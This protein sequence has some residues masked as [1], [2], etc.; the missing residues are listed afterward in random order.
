MK[1]ILCI[2]VD[3]VFPPIPVRSFDW[4]AWID[5]TEERGCYGRGATREAA[6]ADLYEQLEEEE[7]YQ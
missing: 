4:A 3:F 5:G 2:C 1:T 6:V 7:L